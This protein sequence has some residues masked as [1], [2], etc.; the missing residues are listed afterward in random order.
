MPCFEPCNGQPGQLNAPQR[1]PRRC[2]PPTRGGRCRQPRQGSQVLAGGDA[3]AVGKLAALAGG[4]FGE[5][6]SL[7]AFF[8][9]D[10]CALAAVGGVPG[11]QG[12]ED[13]ADEGEDR[14]GLAGLGCADGGAAGDD[15]DQ[16]AAEQ[17]RAG[18][19]R[20]LR[21]FHSAEEDGAP[22]GRPQPKGRFPAGADASEHEGGEV[23]W[24]GGSRACS[25]IRC[26]SPRG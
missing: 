17:A 18:V 23:R 13:R 5:E 2:T 12:D 1:C 24:R 6:G 15:D 26:R 8:R 25:E 19:G 16:A 14:G 11:D 9:E 20:K 3:V 21:M 7:A 4:F 22:G 10:R